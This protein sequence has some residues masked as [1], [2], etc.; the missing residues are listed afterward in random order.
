MTG[1]RLKN[2]LDRY[3]WLV[4]GEEGR[5][6]RNNLRFEL[7]ELFHGVELAG[8]S[9]LDIGAG[10]GH[11]SLFAACAGA[12]K[13]VS[14]EPEAAGSNSGMLDAFRHLTR[15]LDL[16]DLV[17]LRQT[18]FQAYDPGDDRFGVLI[19]NASVN[20]LDEDACARLHR[21]EDAREIYRIIFRKL[22]AVAAPGAKLVVSDCSRHNLFAHLGLR[23]P[24]APTIEWHKHQSP[25]LWAALLEA[26][27]FQRPRIRWRSF[28]SLRTPGK[29]LVGNR[30]A[31]YM[32]TSSFCLTMEMARAMGEAPPGMR[33]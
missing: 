6:R 31:S 18:T 9:V 11:V 26:Q 25:E 30:I 13:V 19:L 15:L 1:T 5:V 3:F 27:G 23:N 17:E 32:L 28:N 10:R 24:V 21:D 2:Q 4:E 7:G 14:L 33:G 16:Q 29:H 20:H 12:N 22:A 8:K